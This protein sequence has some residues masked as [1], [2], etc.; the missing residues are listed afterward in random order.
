[1]IS[2]FDIIKSN[3]SES[4]KNKSTISFK[5]FSKIYKLINEF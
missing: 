5:V 4:N 2:I 3:Y 1:M